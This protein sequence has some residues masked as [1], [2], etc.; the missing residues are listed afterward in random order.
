[1]M[2]IIIT[3]LCISAFCQLHAQTGVTFRLNPFSLEQGESIIVRGNF[4]QWNGNDY[5][6]TRLPGEDLYTGN[7]TLKVEPEDTIEYKFVLLR[8]DG[9]A[10]WERNPNPA[11]QEYGNRIALIGQGG[12]ELPVATFDL[13][14]YF[15]Y[16]VVFSQE[17]LQEEF[18]RVRRLIEEVHPALYDYT[19]KKALESIFDKGFK[20]IDGDL[21]FAD[22]H[23]LLS[24]VIARIGCGHTSIWTPSDYWKIAPERLFPL[25][26]R[27]LEEGTC[28]T[29]TYGQV[30]EVPRGSLLHTVNG[31]PVHE[32][33][34]TLEAGTPADGFNPSNL[35]VRVERDFSKKY[36]LCYGYPEQFR[37]SFTAPGSDQTEEACLLPVSVEQVNSSSWKGDEL[38]FREIE[39][40]STG[41]LAINTFA[42]Y[43]RVDMFHA[44][45]DSVFQVVREREI[46]NLILD[47]RGNAGGDPFCSFYLFSYLQHEPVPYFAE[48]YGKYTPLAEPIPLAGNHFTGN[49]FTL[50]DGYGFSTTGH[51]CA[52]LKYHRIGKF[53]GTE[54]G[55]TYT[56][57]GNVQYEN[58]EHTRII[59]GTA[60][61]RR[62]S[63]AVR[64]MDRKRGVMP[65]YRVEPS[66]Q[67][68]A[69]GTDRVLEFALSLAS[70]KNN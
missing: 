23:V 36:A 55:A 50:I 2:R 5:Q 65:D 3:V 31:I 40:A 10:Y 11:D 12:T 49:L 37:V 19:P 18:V 43:D 56:C 29:G 26:L 68:I 63:A 53:V 33:I 21:D 60:R 20:Q 34:Q 52:L 9:S 41:I 8:S 54:L 51:F 42:Y 13:D 57:T 27:F 66:P 30:E 14:E 47:L 46:G 62:Y 16:P 22:F 45:L 69:K 17:K 61:E 58:L 48:P 64:G 6:L 35:A 59:V 25:K 67:D 4:N 38:S 15:R 1:M 28:V 39:G 44:F 70:E 32:I 24:R 7:F